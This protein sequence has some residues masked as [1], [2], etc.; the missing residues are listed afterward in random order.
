MMLRNL[1]KTLMIGFL[2]LGLSAAQGAARAPMGGGFHGGV[3]GGG[4][5]FSGRVMPARS[6][7]HS[8]FRSFRGVE[9]RGDDFDRGGNFRG[10]FD[11]DRGRRFGG[12]GLYNY[13][14]PWW[15]GF[16]WGY[17]YP[18]YGALYPG[19][20]YAPGHPTGNVKI[21]THMK[22]TRV[23]IDGGYAGTVKER[24]KFSLKPGTHQLELRAADGQ[25]FSEQIYVVKGQ[26]L[27]VKPDFSNQQQ[28]AG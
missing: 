4:H 5:G 14:D 22:D 2:G 3:R 8:G 12:F 18:Y 26:T 11:Y 16:G 15:G 20:Y 9:H 10:N 23:Y 21:E 25:T 1:G 28:P 24:N 19:Y 7:G 17:G 6:E 13:Y 27:K